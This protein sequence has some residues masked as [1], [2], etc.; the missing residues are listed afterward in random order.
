MGERFEQIG[1]KA[2][3]CDYAV[4][5]TTPWNYGLLIDEHTHSSGLTAR[6]QPLGDVPFAPDFRA[7][8]HHRPRLKQVPHWQMEQNS[9][10]TLPQSPVQVDTPLE[11]VELIPYGS[12]NLRIGEFPTITN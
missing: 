5:A 12:T 6:E 4:H 7:C 9:A 8:R 3:H 2:P 11:T 1:G 10:G